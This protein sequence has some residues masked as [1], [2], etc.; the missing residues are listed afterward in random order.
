M[1]TPNFNGG[2]VSVLYNSCFQP[3]VIT[4]PS[5]SLSADVILT[6]TS[7]TTVDANFTVTLSAAT[8]RVVR[9]NYYTSAQTATGT[10][11]YQ[12]AAGT[13]VS[14]ERNEQNLTI[15]VKDDAIDE[16]DETFKV[17]LTNPVNVTL[18]DSQAVVTIVDN[19]ASPAISINDVS[20]VEGNTGTTSAV[21]TVTASAAS[22]KPIVVQFATNGGTATSGIDF[23]RTTGLLTIPARS[24]SGTI[25]VPVNGDLAIEPDEI[26]SLNLSNPVNASIADGQGTGTITNDDTGGTI[27]FSAANYNVNED[28]VS[29]TFTV[30]RTGGTAGGITVQYATS[31]GTAIS[32]QDF[33]AASGTLTFAANET[34]KT[35]TVV[36]INDLIDEPDETGNLVLS[37]PTGGA[38]LGTPSTA[39][40]TIIDND[41]APNITINNVTVS[42]GNT[43]TTNATF[44]VRLS[45]SSG[46]AITV[47]F[48]TANGTATAGSDYTAISGTLTFQPSSLL[49]TVTVPITGDT[50]YEPNEDFT[51]NLTNAVNAAITDGEGRGA[52]VNNDANPNGRTQLVSMNRFGTGSGNN[53]SLS[54]ATTPDG[55]FVAFAS[56]ATNMIANDTNTTL[57]D[58]Y[59]RD[60]E[61]GTT[62]VV[63]IN[64]DNN[65]TGNGNSYAPFIT[66]DA[67]FVLFY[68]IADDLTTVSDTNTFQDV[69][70]RDLQ[71]NTTTLVS[72]NTAGNAA[73]NGASIPVAITPNGRYVYFRSTSSNLSPLTNFFGREHVFV[74]DMQTGVT[75]LISVNAAGNLSGNAAATGVPNGISADGRY[76]LFLS[77]ANDLQTTVPDSGFS[78]DVFIRDRQ[79]NV[80]IPVNVNRTATAFVPFSSTLTMSSDGRYV[81]FASFSADVV[82]G[83][84]NSTTDVFVRDMQANTNLLVSR[85]LAG[86]GSGNAPSEFGRITPNGRFV[87]FTSYASNLTADNDTN[88]T[89][90]IFIRDLQTNTT[91]FVSRKSDN[92]NSGNAFSRNPSVTPDGRFVLFESRRR[93][94]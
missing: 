59:V 21:F 86:T 51:V 8:S 81:T 53:G 78:Q 41:N 15:P 39:I 68:S 54:P 67:R 73:G 2:N 35:F 42:E 63:S 29:A 84:A 28:V 13:L 20:V 49:K 24:T 36:I 1:A 23:V 40:F 38:T 44:T 3:A 5:A 14:A 71:N 93:I 37:N 12:P 6:E 64:R 72:I 19:D 7:G 90:D 34:S 9:V 57:S 27:Q 85:N 43:G 77:E 69:F 62:T 55:R 65:G 31:G 87:A 4:Q 17:F 60:T 10:T 26:F 32:E 52:I 46:R 58:I 74:R 45:A 70:V 25:S 76:V 11:D 94:W 83:D 89:I 33:R 80:T 50:L 18:N 75:E 56:T 48:A 47:D 82:E 61:T 88:Q 22:E 92:T 30:T 66:P 91:R 16:F 79:N